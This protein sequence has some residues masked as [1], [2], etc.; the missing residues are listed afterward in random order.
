MSSKNQLFI[1]VEKIE[2]CQWTLY[3][4]QCEDCLSPGCVVVVKPCHDDNEFEVH[5]S[6]K[7]LSQPVLVNREGGLPRDKVVTINDQEF[8]ILMGI[9]HFYDKE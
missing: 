6:A 3:D 8:D 1:V 2:Q 7:I 9:H 5:R 4:V